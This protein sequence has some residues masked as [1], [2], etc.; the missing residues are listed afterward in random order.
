[1]NIKKI[2][3]L[4]NKKYNSKDLEKTVQNDIRELMDAMT[5][6]V[7][8]INVFSG[9]TVDNRFIT[10]GA[11]KGYPDLSGYLPSGVALFI[12]VKRPNGKGI[13]SE[14]QKTFE[15]DAVNNH[16]IYI[17]AK[18]PKEVFNRLLT[19]RSVR[20]LYEKSKGGK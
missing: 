9:K 12:E 15:R 7:F 16:A 10:S 2:N 11:P 5:I 20:N 4:I 18:N 17:L 8:R 13:Q 6:K 19:I 1:M 3:E 14:F